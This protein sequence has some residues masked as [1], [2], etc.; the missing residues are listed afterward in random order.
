MWL[1]R[2]SIYLLLPLLK[3][4]QGQFVIMSPLLPTS[5][6]LCSTPPQGASAGGASS[7]WSRQPARTVTTA[8]LT[9]V[10][11]TTTAYGTTTLVSSDVR[12]TTVYS[13]A[14]VTTSIAGENVTYT[15]SGDVVTQTI[16][17]STVFVTLS[18]STITITPSPQTLT[19]STRDVSTAP[20]ELDTPGSARPGGKQLCKT[21]ARSISQAIQKSR[22]CISDPSTQRRLSNNM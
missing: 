7:A 22:L 19:L 17:P 1:S 21:S 11:G 20:G 16:S 18:A 15:Q 12:T 3:V 8:I 9:T 5:A 13:S 6:N 4:P 2:Q 14:V 10:F